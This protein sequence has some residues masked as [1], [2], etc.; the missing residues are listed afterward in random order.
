MPQEKYNKTKTILY[1]SFVFLSLQ[2]GWANRLH[3]RVF[4]RTAWR[5]A[6]HSKESKV[7]AHC[8]QRFDANS[9]EFLS[10]ILSDLRVIEQEQV[11]TCSLD[12]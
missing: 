5:S 7:T 6:R 9:I 11:Y 10:K 12:D 8:G 1:F 3:S 2:S 4:K